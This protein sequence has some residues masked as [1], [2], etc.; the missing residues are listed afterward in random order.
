MDQL[1]KASAADVGRLR[2]GTGVREKLLGRLGK[3]LLTEDHS[4]R[5]SSKWVFV[6]TCNPR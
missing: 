2:V 6:Y 1:T 4:A 3:E 5:Q